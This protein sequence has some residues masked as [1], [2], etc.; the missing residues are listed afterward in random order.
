MRSGDVTPRKCTDDITVALRHARMVSFGTAGIRGD[1]ASYLPPET[2]VQIGRAISPLGPEVVVGRD[3]RE[4]GEALVDA[5]ASGLCSGGSDVVRIGQV[6]TPALA[7]ASR[8]RIGVMITA[9]HNP[10]SDNGVKV[11]QDGSE[12]DRDVERAIEGRCSKEYAPADWDSWGGA[13]EDDVLEE[14]T[15]A[16]CEYVETI[17][18]PPQ[19]LTI[20]IDCGNGVGA[21]ATPSVLHDIGVETRTVNGRLDGRF[22]AR[23]S[24]PTPEALD[25]FRS[26]VGDGPYDL[27]FAHDG[28]ADR[29]VVIDERGDLVHEDTVLAILA[30][31]YV[32]TSGCADP[33]VLTTPNAST[34][35]DERVAAAGGSVERTALGTLHEGIAS[36]EDSVTSPQRRVV[37]AAEPWKHIHPDF[38]PWIDGVASAGVF[39]RL[40]AEAGSLDRLREPVTERPYRK[41]SL[42]CPPHAA[43]DVLDTLETE[44]PTQFPGAS[45]TTTHGI[46]VS[47]PDGGWI[48]VRPS[49]TEPKIRMYAEDPDVD[50]L[51]G[52]V[53]EIVE[54]AIDQAAQ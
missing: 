44:L 46:R 11:F 7:Y 24:A 4:S 6:P 34:R 28:D 9:S 35:I 25:E 37:F 22:P 21:L 19:D 36:I 39:V 2:V 26:Y 48:L 8:E 54:V 29:L 5:I 51:L 49:G 17:G 15:T 53:R 47:F 42:P 23:E 41:E 43:Q 13:R 50:T 3:A 20:A 1:V 40:I 45:V 30:H 31:A 27:G 52:D 12:I 32:S 10:P 16:V 38:G 33:V 14:Y 18:E